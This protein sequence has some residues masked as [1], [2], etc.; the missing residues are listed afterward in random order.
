MKH[1]TSYLCRRQLREELLL[2]PVPSRTCLCVNS[3]MWLKIQHL[4]PSCPNQ[5]LETIYVSKCHCLGPLSCRQFLRALG[6]PLGWI[7][8][9]WPLASTYRNPL[10]NDKEESWPAVPAFT[11]WN[12]SLF[13]VKLIA[14][15]VFLCPVS[16]AITLLLRNLINISKIL[17]LSSSYN[18]R[19]VSGWS[20]KLKA[21]STGK[22]Y[23]II[24]VQIRTFNSSA[25]T[26]TALK[27]T[28]SLQQ[29]KILV[30]CLMTHRHE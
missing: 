20:Q 12:S 19:L 7:S 18:H 22:M 15:P 13:C 6:T 21:T 27:S 10:R 16:M 29:W 26:Q 23:S 3:S 17:T 4:F 11:E 2:S 30:S 1:Q 24:L 5:P 28:C 14:I 25:K 8:V 9:E